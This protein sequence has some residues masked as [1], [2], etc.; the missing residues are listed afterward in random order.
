MRLLAFG[1]PLARAC[2]EPDVGLP[3]EGLERGGELCQA[4]GQ[5]PTAFGRIPG[6]PGP[7]DQGTTGMGRPRR[8]HA[9]LRPARPTGIWR[10]CQPQIMHALSR[11]RNACEGAPCRHGGH[12]DGARH[13]APS[14]EGLDHG[15]EAPG[16]ALLVACECKPPQTFRLFRDGLDLFL[17]DHLRCRRGTPHLAAPAQ[18]GRAPV[19][20][21]CRADI[22]PPHERLPTPLRCLQIPEGSCPRP[23]QV[24]D[25]GIVDGRDRDGREVPGA[26]EPGQLHGVTP[27]GFDPIACLCGHQG[28]SDDP[29]G[30]A[31]LRQVAREPGAAR[32][33]FVDEDE[34][35]A[36]GLEP[37]EKLVAITLPRP[38]R[39]EGD[40]VRAVFLGT[41]GDGEGLLMDI[42]ANGER[43][44]L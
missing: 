25:R 7:F 34:L 32:A 27:V 43:A 10:G 38:N 37:P 31:L 44:R 40:D 15:S 2:A 35:L 4:Q 29:A 22:V 12:G 24:A 28:G 6:G 33:G 16:C 13:T 3:A 42:H 23:T 36:C 20:P 11:V 30:G 39:P 17:K 21:P 5:G 14:L 41:L 9:T 18:V 1:P 26:Q 19:G 8:G